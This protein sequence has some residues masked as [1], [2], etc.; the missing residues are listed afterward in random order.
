MRRSLSVLAPFALLL[1]ACG[2]D[3]ESA[4]D[5]AFATALP[6]A[7]GSPEALS[8]MALVNDASVDVAELD[9]PA[10]LDA[11]AAK[12][13][14]AW[15]DGPD[16][17]VRTGDDDPFD[18]LAEL[19]DVKYVGSKTIQ[20]LF[21]YAQ[22]QGYLEA[23]LRKERH[24]VFSPQP[25][26]DSHV[27]DIADAIDGAERSVDVLMYSFSDAGVLAAL[28]RAKDRGVDVRF[29]FDPASKDKSKTGSALAATMSAKIEQL[30]ID[31]RYVNKILHH[32]M[33]IIDGPRDDLDSAADATVITG[34]GNW[35]NGAATKYDENTLFMTAYPELTLRMQAEFNLLW[36]ASRDFVYDP[37]LAFDASTLS[38][39]EET[40]PEGPAL[41]A[42]YTSTNFS[43]SNA[44]TFSSTG[45]NTVA[46]E[47][48][49]AIQGAQTSIHVASGHLRSRPLAE[50]LMAKIAES[51]DLDVRVLLD[52][53]EW[54]SQSYDTSQKKA[55]QNCL[56]AAGTDAKKQRACVDKG[57]YFGYQVGAAGIDVRYKLYAYRWDVSYALQMHHKYMVVDGEAL[58]TGSYNLSDNAEHET[59]ENMLLFRGPEFA[60]LVAEY[61]QNF[62]TLWEL[63]RAE[64]LLGELRDQIESA[65]EVPLTFA[66]MALE[67]QEV[68]DLKTLIR[69]ECPLADSE[70]YRTNPAAH[71]VCPK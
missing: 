57:Y 9:G 7:E 62:A 11:R 42:F 2:G 37:A 58:Y 3:E 26:A 39:T 35:S 60:G 71:K 64:D 20:T 38:I 30:G 52:G 8:V 46:D 70:E 24:V 17:T 19:D 21:A 49:R 1:A 65:T 29:L 10:K 48:V 27:I 16:A 63:G 40:I 69:A 33:A 36:G 56:A 43:L 59:F 61:E 5:E 50:A 53:Q 51:P 23:E 45:A 25:Y 32:K 41:H 47:L 68:A 4:A 18:R 55:L 44:T 14:I 67:W 12:A 31:V 6:Y 15:R 34:S 54:I 28:D 66:P 13:V 22:A